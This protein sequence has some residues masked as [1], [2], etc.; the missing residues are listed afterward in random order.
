MP[1]CSAQYGQCVVVGRPLVIR[2]KPSKAR[3]L[4]RCH[5]EP[6]AMDFG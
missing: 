3:A 6:L 4:L 5:H 1:H 2:V